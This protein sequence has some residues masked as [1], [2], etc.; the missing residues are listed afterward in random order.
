MMYLISLGAGVHSPTDART[1]T[2]SPVQMQKASIRHCAAIW[3]G[4]VMLET[5][6]RIRRSS[7]DHRLIEGQEMSSTIVESAV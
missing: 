6:F 4:S 7:G 1:P 5:F 2:R 3:E